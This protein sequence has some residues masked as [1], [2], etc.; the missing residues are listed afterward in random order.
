MATLNS[1]DFTGQISSVSNTSKTWDFLL[2]FLQL[3]LDKKIGGA[4]PN[5]FSGCAGASGIGCVHYRFW[6]TAQ[7]PIEICHWSLANESALWSQTNVGFSPEFLPEYNRVLLC[8]L[9]CQGG[10][11]PAQSQQPIN[12]NRK[13]PLQTDY[14][15]YTGRRAGGREVLKEQTTLCNL[16]QH[17]ISTVGKTSRYPTSL[18]QSSKNAISCLKADQG[19]PQLSTVFSPDH[20]G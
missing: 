9:R 6:Q 13:Q 2:L 15:G 7:T 17:A 19:F 1:S 16:S 12:P 3:Y 18:N 10:H 4:R 8:K 14:C 5:I 11:H 20:R